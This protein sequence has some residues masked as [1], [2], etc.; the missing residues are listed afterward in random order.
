MKNFIFFFLILFEACL[1]FRVD[2][3]E[4]F[5]VGFTNK[6]NSSFTLSNPGEYLSE[7]AIYR[8]TKQN[9]PIDSFDLPVNQ[10]YI[11]QVLLPGVSLVHSQMDERD[12]VKAKLT[13]FSQ[14]SAIT[15][16]KEIQRTKPENS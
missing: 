4:Y 12:T 3:Q 9:I 14:N 5:W 6:M 8:R 13:A 2:A 10:N 7:R 16:V 15:F 11:E 1:V